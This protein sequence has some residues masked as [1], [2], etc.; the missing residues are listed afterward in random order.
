[1]ILYTAEK[2]VY[3]NYG[4]SIAAHPDKKMNVYVNLTNRCQCACTFCLRHTKKLTEKNTLWIQQ[5][6]TADEVE[7][8]LKKYD[9][10]K[11]GEIVF[12]G[13]GEPTMALEVLLEVAAYIKNK[14]PDQKIR[15]NTNGLANLTYGKD[16]TGRFNGL[17]DTM[18]ISLNASNAGEYL[19]LTRNRFGLASYQGMLDFAVLCKRHAPHVVLT[20]VDCVGE[21]EIAACRKVC[22]SVAIPLRVRTFE[23]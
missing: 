2:G 22:E 6:P 20:V 5:E 23:V 13:F 18:S 14:R 12:C 21:E 4:D 3:V 7:A 19:R 15:V 8:E 16:V 1:M 11:F 10:D 17:I 9:W